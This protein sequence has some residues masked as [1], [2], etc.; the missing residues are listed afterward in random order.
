MK[1]ATSLLH[2]FTVQKLKITAANP[3]K[4]PATITRYTKPYRETL[5]DDLIDLAVQT[6]TTCGK[7][8]LF[9]SLID[10]ARTWRLVVEA[11]AEGKL[12]PTSKVATY[13][14]NSSKDERVIC[15]YTYDFTDSL[16]VRRV[17]D[18]LV[19]LGLCS[20]KMERGIFYKCD[21]WTYLDL[22]SG[23]EYGIKVS[24]Y[25]SKDMLADDGRTAFQKGGNV[26]VVEGVI[27]RFKRSRI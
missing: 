1:G 11:T 12:G 4:A 19:E 6:A 20:G 7:W 8:M 17:L 16:D 10:L 15:V 21:A 24:L 5:E 2:A 13:D 22:M 25:S 23:N 26:K 27:A 18:E 3:E 14:S 9:P